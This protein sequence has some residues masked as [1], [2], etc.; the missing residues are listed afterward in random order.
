M[1]VQKPVSHAP[2]AARCMVRTRLAARS[3][4][5]TRLRDAALFHHLLEDVWQ[6]RI[7]GKDVLLPIVVRADFLDGIVQLVGRHAVRDGT[8]CVHTACQSSAPASVSKESVSKGSL[9][10]GGGADSRRTSVLLLCCGAHTRVS[11][12]AGMRLQE[13]LELFGACCHLND[14]HA[15]VRCGR[16]VDPVSRYERYWDGSLRVV[17]DFDPDV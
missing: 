8:Q 11:V 16:N 14:P 3:S 5:C 12:H 9:I 17:H 6:P 13:H 1:Y 7:T 15:P 2:S 10:R 4:L